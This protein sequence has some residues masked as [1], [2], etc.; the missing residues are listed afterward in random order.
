MEALFLCWQIVQIVFKFEFTSSILSVHF[1]CCEMWPPNSFQ[2]L[3]GGSLTVIVSVS[4]LSVVYVQLEFYFHHYHSF[5]SLLCFLTFLAS[6][7]FRFTWVCSWETRR[8]CR[9]LLCCL[10]MSWVT[11]AQ[12]QITCRFWKKWCDWSLIVM[13]ICCLCSDLWTR[14][15]VAKLVLYTGFHN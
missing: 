6:C 10:C 12:Q 5:V 14:E 11:E 8:W 13:C 2:C 3:S 9:Y 15:L 7:L 1:Q 4:P